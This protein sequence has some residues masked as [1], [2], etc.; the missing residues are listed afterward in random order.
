V[1]PNACRAWGIS[2]NALRLWLPVTE[3]RWLAEAREGEPTPWTTAEDMARAL[4]AAL[5]YRDGFQAFTVSGDYEQKLT[6]VTKAKRLLDWEPLAR[7]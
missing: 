2:V 7:P 6:N 5:E 1:Y 4:L 3:E